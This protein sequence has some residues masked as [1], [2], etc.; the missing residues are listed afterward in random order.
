MNRKLSGILALLTLA[1]LVLVACGGAATTQAPPTDTPPS[2]A[3]A[4]LKIPTVNCCRGQELGAGRYEFPSWLGI[5][6][7]VDVGEGWRVLNEQAALLF[8][9]GRGMN[10]QNNPSQLIVFINVTGKTTPEALIDLVQGAPELTTLSEPAIVTLAGFPG[11]Q[12]DS[13]A[14]PNASY[15]GSE[16]QDIPPGV[17][18]LPVFKEYFTPGFLWTT[19]SPEARLRTIV[20]TVDDQTLLLYLEAPPKEFDQF[21]A[22]AESILQSLELIEK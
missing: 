18:F 12:L 17:Q 22:D 7:T 21:A 14:K 4:L 13:T 9:L 3:V 19:S 1:T 8:L 5:P 20:L 16:A 6:L 15:E 2:T 11:M 10:V